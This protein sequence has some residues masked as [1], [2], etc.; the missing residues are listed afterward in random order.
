MVRPTTPIRW[1][2]WPSEEPPYEELKDLLTKIWDFWGEHGRIRE[3]VGE[4]ILRVGMSNFLE[5][6]GLEPNPYMI[7]QPRDNPY[8]YFDEYYEEE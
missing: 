3:R 6:I 7:S 5:A 4:L 2:T 8:I 1:L